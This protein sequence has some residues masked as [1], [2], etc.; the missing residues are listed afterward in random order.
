MD[1]LE[2]F[3]DQA[4]RLLCGLVFAVQSAFL[5]YYLIFHLNTYWFI[6]ILVDLVVVG[7]MLYAFIVTYLYKR[8]H[9]TRFMPH[10]YPGELP[11]AYSCWFFYS[12][13]LAVRVGILY[14]TVAGKLS[15]NVF[16]GPNLLQFSIVLAVLFLYFLIKAVSLRKRG[17][18]K[19][20]TELRIVCEESLN[21]IDGAELL[22]ILFSADNTAKLS[23]GLPDALIAFAC[24]S[25]IVPTINLAVYSRTTYED[26]VGI[27]RVL[28]AVYVL[29][30]LFLINLPL[31]VLRMVIWSNSRLVSSL[32]LG[33][34][35]I[36]MGIHFL[37]VINIIID[38]EPKRYDIEPRPH[39]EDLQ[40]RPA[41]D[42]SGPTTLNNE[43]RRRQLPSS[44]TLPTMAPKR[45]ETNA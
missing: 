12:V 39:R 32:F 18:L 6:W 34:N 27:S 28:R 40:R 29:A 7:V 19:Q 45:S 42:T 8:G 15:A 43:P 1:R 11:L 36:F 22:S 21:I 24:L 37:D 17:F 3:G 31:L 38:Q 30:A 25:F 41:G 10:P 9:V 26:Q 2:D 4:C 5:D 23:A 44:T 33:K 20:S 13:A 35:M 16:F 14:K